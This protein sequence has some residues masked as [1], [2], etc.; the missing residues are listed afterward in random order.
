MGTLAT[1]DDVGPAARLARE[2]TVARHALALAGWVGTGGRPVTAGRVLRRA[3]VA[4]AGAVLGV[5]VPARV[6]T[7][8]DVGDLH[9][10]WC[11]AVAM[12]LIR[13]GGGR[14][15]SGPALEFWPLSDAESLAGWLAGLRAVCAAESYPQ[16]EDSVRL[17]ARALLMVLAGADA[18]S[19]GRGLWP[20]VC[21]AVDEVCEMHDKSYWEPLHAADRY[22]ELESDDPTAGL[23]TLLAGFGA[24][25]AGPGGPT[26]TPLGRWAA[27]R[28]CADLPA[29]ASPRLTAA[30][31]ITEFARFAEEEQQWHVAWGW[32]A[33]RDPA[34][35]ARDILTAAEQVSPLQ[36]LR[37]VGVAE[38]L[39]DNALPAWRELAA[40][41]CVGPHARAVLAGIGQGPEPDDADRRWLAAEAAAA[42]AEDKGPDEALSCVSDAIAGDGLDDQLAVV[43]ATGHP[44]AGELARAITEFAASGAPRS[45]AQ[46]VQLK[47][48]LDRMRRP[49]WRRVRV[50]AT[51]TL[52]DL[53]EVIQVVY[54]W[55]GDHLH[56]FQVGK[57]SYSDPF[58]GL[59][60]T[61]DEEETR[62]GELAASGAGKISYTYDLGACW[63]H[64]ITLEGTLE[65]EPGRNYPVCAEFSGD[66]P[67]EYPPEEDGSGD[68]NDEPAQPRRFSL[69][70]VN[71]KLA[72]LG[73]RGC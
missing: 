26:I 72:A 64:E 46:V 52:G 70:D 62:L 49:I 7:A 21:K 20:A 41:P 13:V 65:R 39:G 38:R 59:D 19:P 31:L 50:P 60:E 42:A 27:Q 9:R 24:A 40:A 12:G 35:A 56:V 2:C 6:R 5:P 43:R 18:A 10:P 25:A 23:V 54:G 51:A 11:L 73:L 14:V 67:E 61:R 69:A 16:D 17:L 58:A 47:V 45:I 3:D 32:L 48:S 53:H 30:E 4:A 68:S 44:G 63:Q 15:S 29:L 71:R 8:A 28:I 36:R 34:H 33:E 1:G 22:R 66:S 37:A 57:K 55:D